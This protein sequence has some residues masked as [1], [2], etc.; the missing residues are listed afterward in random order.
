MLKRLMT[1]RGPR[2]SELQKSVSESDYDM[3]S[4][5]SLLTVPEVHLGNI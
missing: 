3:T 4:G 5:S 2:N 1:P